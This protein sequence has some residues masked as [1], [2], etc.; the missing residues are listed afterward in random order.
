MGGCANRSAKPDLL[1]TDRSRVQKLRMD[2]LYKTHLTS[3]TVLYSPPRGTL[4][5]TRHSGPPYK[6][7]I[8][9]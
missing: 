3:R 8:Q 4:A 6:Y 5:S 2:V 1:Q 7:A 9:K